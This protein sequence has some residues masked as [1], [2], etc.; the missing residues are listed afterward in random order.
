MSSTVQHEEEDMELSEGE[1]KEKEGDKKEGVRKK[2]KLNPDQ[3]RD[4]SEE[5][6]CQ[7]QVFRTGNKQN[8]FQIVR[9]IETRCQE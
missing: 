6:A 1:E 8:I 2:R 5:W 3:L 9:F 7:A 4:E